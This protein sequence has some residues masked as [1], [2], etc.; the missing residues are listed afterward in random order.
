MI[1]SKQWHGRSR[2]W[3]GLLVHLRWRRVENPS[4]RRERLCHY[5][6]YCC[7]SFFVF[8]LIAH[9]TIVHAQHLRLYACAIANDG[10][11]AF[12]GGSSN[13]SGLYQSDDTGKTWEHLGWNNIKC[14]SMDVVHFS[15]GRILYEATGL[16][17]LRSIDYGTTWKQLTDWR[18]S[19]VMDVAVSQKNPE[20]IYIATAH[21]PWK[22]TDEG[23][24]WLAIRDG[25]RSPYCSHI[26]F[27]PADS[28]KLLLT[29]E[30]GLYQRKESR[31]H[32]LSRKMKPSYYLNFKYM[33][34][35]YKDVAS[36]LRFK[37]MLLIGT[38]GDGIWVE[39]AHNHLLPHL[40]I[41]TLKSF[42]VTP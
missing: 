5:R 15:N 32:K 25:M 42:F 39:P 20:E 17:V 30:D 2:L 12:M 22:S 19:E 21:G 26:M 1:V 41:W 36:I 4:H 9:T 24:S 29:A 11:G 33:D 13:G 23:K 16:G 38:L 8:L 6:L 37:R 14:Y 7:F 10:A 28:T 35:N 31:W 18:V 27:D 3:G 40:Q 34:Y